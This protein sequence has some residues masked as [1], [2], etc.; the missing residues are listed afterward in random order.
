MITI[1]F[2]KLLLSFKHYKIFTMDFF[3]SFLFHIIE[4]ILIG[5]FVKVITLFGK[6]VPFFFFLAVS[7]LFGYI[8]SKGTREIIERFYEKTFLYEILFK[9]IKIVFLAKIFELILLNFLR[10]FPLF[11]LIYFFLTKTHFSLLLPLLSLL[12]IFPA[13]TLA[14]FFSPLLLYFRGEEREVIIHNLHSLLLFIIPPMFTYI[15]FNF[16]ENIKYLPIIGYV[17]ELRKYALL[18][19]IDWKVFIISAIENLILFIF[20]VFFFLKTF[21]YARRKGWIGLR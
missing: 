6:D 5:A 21:D 12:L 4:W 20:G 11:L 3:L 15:A 19:I 9:G 1:Y 14:L 7:V 13:I 16:Y 2:E 8:V 10:F 18:G 17:E